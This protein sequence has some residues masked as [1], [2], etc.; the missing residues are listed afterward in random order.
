MP[1]VQIVSRSENFVLGDA[2]Q[3]Y[4]LRRM[5]PDVRGQIRESH[6]TTLEA[7]T[8]GEPARQVTDEREVSK[9]VLDY[10]VQE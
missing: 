10:L 5:H 8:S 4:R 3:W 7:E 2:E 9:D 1:K 6:T